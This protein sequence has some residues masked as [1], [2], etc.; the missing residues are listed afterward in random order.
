MYTYSIIIPHKNCPNLLQRC[1]NSIPERE[2]IQ[3]I[4]IDDNSDADKK[5]SIDR[6]GVEVVLLD[7]EH[8][9]GAGRARNV[10]LERAKG[11]W[12]LFADSDDFYTKE[13]FEVL[14]KYI[15]TDFELVYYN[16]KSVNSITMEPS[17]RTN[18]INNILKVYSNNS[19][20]ENVNRL[21]YNVHEPW[22][23]LVRHSFLTKHGIR[24]E[25]VKKANDILFTFMVGFFAKKIAV[26]TD[27]VY[28]CTYRD[29]SITYSINKIEYAVR[30]FEFELCKNYFFKIYSFNNLKVPSYIVLL[31]II[32]NLPVSC[33]LE[34]IKN[35][36]INY[37]SISKNKTKYVDTAKEIVNKTC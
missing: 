8:S 21:K 27:F 19:C 23:K 9:K 22:N 33:W 13:A 15:D 6:N 24:F 17:H 3:I 25:E 31:R 29:N 26:E 11:K 37:K 4:V 16:C 18:H 34:F 1:M 28:V 5:P 30:R 32:K 7:A 20:K 10:G 36:F 35:L 2:D 12:L 14:D